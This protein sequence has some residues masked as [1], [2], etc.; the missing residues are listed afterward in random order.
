MLRQGVSSI[1]SAP[2]IHFVTKQI[3]LN[4]LSGDLEGTGRGSRVQ[5]R[6]LNKCVEW[7][8]RLCGIQEIGSPGKVYA[9]RRFIDTEQYWGTYSESSGKPKRLICKM[10]QGILWEELML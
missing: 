2:K 8:R 6:D 4:P 7:T 1:Y 10:L 9:D 3:A 5:S